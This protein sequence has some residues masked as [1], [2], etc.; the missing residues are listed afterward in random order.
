[1]ITTLEV[2]DAESMNVSESISCLCLNSEHLR[3][4]VTARRE[5]KQNGSGLGRVN[6]K[7]NSRPATTHQLAI[8]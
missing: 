2:G 3:V 1:M 8:A 6:A 7:E 4:H 5:L